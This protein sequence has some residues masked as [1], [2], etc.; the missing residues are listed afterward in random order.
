MAW[1]LA[2]LYLPKFKR[3]EAGIL[4]AIRWSGDGTQ[5]DWVEG[6]LDNLLKTLQSEASHLGVVAGV[7]LNVRRLPGH[8]RTSTTEQRDVLFR[9]SK[10]AFLIAADNAQVGRTGGRAR[11]AMGR[12]QFYVRHR[13]LP[14]GAQREFQRDLGQIHIPARKYD[15]MFDNDIVEVQT[16]AANLTLVARYQ[17]GLAAAVNGWRTAAIQLLEDALHRDTTPGRWPYRDKAQRVAANLL[18]LPWALR[19]P[20]PGDDASRIAQALT[21]AEHASQLAPSAPEPHEV[22][23]AC[24]FLAGDLTAAMASNGLVKDRLPLATRGVWRLN[25]A[26]F[27]LGQKDFDGA[28][29]EYERALPT[30]VSPDAPQ[31]IAMSL[32]WLY[33][34]AD[35]IGPEFLFGCA[36]LNDV[37][38]DNSV[39]PAEY[40]RVLPLLP[41]GAARVLAERRIAGETGPAGRSHPSD[42]G[43]TKRRP[44]VEQRHRRRG[45]RGRR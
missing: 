12:V 42:D 35:H 21:D 26:V 10:A 2:R 23:A 45:R 16:V 15:V 17:L 27:A 34:A 29:H 1:A 39:A 8:Y 6:V 22:M 30:I 5:R 36:Y 14:E 41:V 9:R 33:A 44:A 43:Q 19:P 38:F 7:R 18:V 20:T 24:H 25:A 13:P 28:L 3:G 31:I 32:A 37:M 40:A 4:V 11:I